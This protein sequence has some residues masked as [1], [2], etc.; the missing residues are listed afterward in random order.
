[1]KKIRLPITNKDRAELENARK[2]NLIKQLYALRDGYQM[3]IDEVFKAYPLDIFPDT[4]QG[5][6]DDVIA[7]YPGFIDRTSAMMGRHIAKVIK[8]RATYFHLEI[9][10]GDSGV[11]YISEKE[12]GDRLEAMIDRMSETIVELRR[13]LFFSSEE[14]QKYRERVENLEKMITNKA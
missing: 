4:T 12:R 8:E 3:A 7:R 5:M 6:R 2:E 11:L 9:L 13:Q 1:M 14:T 10:T